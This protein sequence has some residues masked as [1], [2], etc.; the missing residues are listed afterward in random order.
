MGA[1]SA[2]SACCV[3]ARRRDHALRHPGQR[4][5]ARRAERGRRKR[6]TAQRRIQGQALW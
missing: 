4:Q 1:Q 3:G 2:T 5:P 6:G